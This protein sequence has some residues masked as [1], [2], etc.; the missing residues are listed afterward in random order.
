MK[1][2]E[3]KSALRTAASG[4]AAAPEELLSLCRREYCSH[5]RPRRAGRRALV[6]SQMRFTALPVWALQG[7]LLIFICLVLS[8]AAPNEDL[9]P[10]CASISA[11]LAAL[12]LLPFCNR[13]ARFGMRE[14]EAA[15][16]FNTPRLM[17]AR[18]V[19]VGMGDAVCVSAIALLSGGAA[20]EVLVL[21]VMPFLLTCALSPRR[22]GTRGGVRGGRCPPRWARCWP[23][24]TGYSR[25]LH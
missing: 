5:P 15:A 22:F 9:V 3:L 11:E 4:N 10:A 18:L 1:T 19:A 17:L 13:A 6:R 7:A 25:E 21:V 8:A 12:T 24:R 2:L 23:R 20:Y 16:R 14:V